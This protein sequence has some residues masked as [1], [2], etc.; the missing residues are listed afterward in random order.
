M[1]VFGLKGDNPSNY[2]AVHASKPTQPK[3]GHQVPPFLWGQRPKVVSKQPGNGASG[4]ATGVDQAPGAKI[5]EMGICMDPWTFVIPDLAYSEEPST[6]PATGVRHHLCIRLSV[7]AYVVE[8]RLRMK[9]VYVKK[10]SLLSA[11]TFCL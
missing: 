8:K 3:F 1:A 4:G 10:K 9:E 5:G 6:S 11:R 7:K 2:R